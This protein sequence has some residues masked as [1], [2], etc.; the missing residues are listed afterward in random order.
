[1]NVNLWAVILPAIALGLLV[2]FG[3]STTR[4]SH[5]QQASDLTVIVSD[6]PRAEA[7]QVRATLGEANIVTAM[8]AR[9][10]DDV[11]V[12]VSPDDAQAARDLLRPAD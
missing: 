8:T 3:R 11:D 5:P 9:S 6:V 12:L 10:D 2:L 4:R 7:M 1:M